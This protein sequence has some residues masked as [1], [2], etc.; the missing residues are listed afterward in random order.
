MWF[1]HFRQLYD[2]GVSYNILGRFVK[3]RRMPR[4]CVKKHPYI[5]D[6]FVQIYAS[7]RLDI[8]PIL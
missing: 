1:F 5:M 4:D 7:L 8:P 2:H 6:R 3:G